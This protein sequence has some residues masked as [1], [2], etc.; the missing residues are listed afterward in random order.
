[1]VL[2]KQTYKN[3]KDKHKKPQKLNLTKP[4]YTNPGLVAF[5]TPGQETDLVGLYY[6][7]KTTALG[8]RTGRIGGQRKTE[9]QDGDN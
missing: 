1:M 3:I 4:Y 8:A 9:F 7:K 6:N 2:I 5:T